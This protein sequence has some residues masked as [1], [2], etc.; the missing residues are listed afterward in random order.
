[1]IASLITFVVNLAI[2][3][4]LTPYI[5]SSVGAEAYG[6]VGLAN[7]I[8]NYAT[9]ITIALNSVAGRFI[10][11]KYHQ[12]KKKAAD[13]YF[14]SVFFS[15]VFLSLLLIAVSIPLI[16]NLEKIV[17]ISPKLV[18]DVKFL[19][20]FIFINFVLNVLSTNFTVATF[21]TN[22]L[23]LSSIANVLAALV[24]IFLMVLLFS[25]LKSHVTYVGIATCVS[26]VLLLALN[27]LYTQRLIPDMQIRLR[28]LSFYRI[29]QLFSA[30]VWNS[31]VKLAQI[32][33][34][35]LDLLLANLFVGPYYMGILSVSEVVSNAIS[36]L[37]GTISNLFSPNLTFYYAKGQIMEMVVELKLS[38]KVTGFFTNIAF[39]FVTI[40]GLDFFKLWTPHQDI[41]LLWVLCVL[42]MSSFIISGATTPL[43]NV[44]L[45]TNRLKLISF[46]WLANGVVNIVLVL[47]LLKTTHY[48]IYAVAVVSQIS[49]S[50]TNLVFLPVYASICLKI[51]AITFYK[52]LFRYVFTSLVMLLCFKLIQVI[53]PFHTF[54]WMALIISGLVCVAWGICVNFAILFNRHEQ[55]VFVSTS[56]RFLKL[57]G[58]S[59]L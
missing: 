10:T 23:H 17:H 57:G 7:D 12:G 27:I 2:G 46:I 6:F 18:V 43:S 33:S 25:T 20:L 24:K 9:I 52:T 26:S 53:L 40:F 49:G 4:V 5:V 42:T 13:Q 58:K 36:V 30:G 39:C 59:K 55:K 34:D 29:K 22:K 56:K 48:G 44:F 54:S 32:L 11:I 50:V 1:M 38:M 47:I 21:I 41:H 3:F 45:I 19:F 8:I 14:T 51:K 15:N 31:V 37:M 35:G 16:I 28:Y